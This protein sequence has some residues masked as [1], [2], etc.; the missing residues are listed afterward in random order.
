MLQRISPSEASVPLVPTPSVATCTL[1]PVAPSSVAQPAPTLAYP[2]HPSQQ[3]L[4]LQFSHLR[5][6]QSLTL[7]HLQNPSPLPRRRSRRNKL[8][9]YFLLVSK[10]VFL[11]FGFNTFLW[12]TLNL[13]F[14][15]CFVPLCQKRG[16]TLIFH[17]SV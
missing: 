8:L 6:N 2:Q 5:Q 14:L 16:E 9:F 12:K 3:N 4:M 10:I 1:A 7:Q 17:I 15:V 13:L 11:M